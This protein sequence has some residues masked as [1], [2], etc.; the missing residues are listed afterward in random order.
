MCVAGNSIETAR[1][2]LMSDSAQFPDGLA[3][4]SGQV[5][6]NYMRHLTGSVYAIFD[7]PVHM[8]RGETM[9][10]IITDESGNDTGRA[11]SSAA[12]T[13]SCCRSACVPRRVPRPGRV[14]P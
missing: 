13:W 10:G 12:T 8:H 2:L 7:K 3:N 11:G 14:G 5:G 1:L 4:S 9:A 6:R